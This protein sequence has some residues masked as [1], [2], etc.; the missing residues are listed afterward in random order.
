MPIVPGLRENLN[1][2]D[3]PS[4]GVFDTRRTVTKHRPRGTGSLSTRERLR[5]FA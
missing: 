5:K 3:A 1:I 2:I 4:E